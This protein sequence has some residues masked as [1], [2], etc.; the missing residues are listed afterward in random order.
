M[1]K[2]DEAIIILN[3]AIVIDP[4]NSNAYNNKGISYRNKN[5]LQSALDCFEKAT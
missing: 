1:G 5:E 3:Q 2:Y 4:N